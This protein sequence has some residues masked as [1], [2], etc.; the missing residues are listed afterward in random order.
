VAAFHAGEVPAATEAGADV[1]AEL[2]AALSGHVAAYLEAME[3]VKLKEG[4]RIL[5]AVSAAGN[6]FFQ[7][8]GRR[9]QARPMGPL[10]GL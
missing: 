2:G 5:M 3:R 10:L 1:A 8:G 9:A 7:V 6:K 4:V